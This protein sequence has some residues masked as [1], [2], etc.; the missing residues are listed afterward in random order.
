MRVVSVCTPRWAADL[1]PIAG[2]PAE[3]VMRS[4]GRPPGAWSSSNGIGQLNSYA[5]ESA[6]RGFIRGGNWSYGGL[7]GVLTLYLTYAP[8]DAS[9]SIGFRVSR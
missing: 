3:A 9:T 7:A 2:V 1:G 8:G 6:V 5:G 4:S